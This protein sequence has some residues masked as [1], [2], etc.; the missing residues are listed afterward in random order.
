ME[1]RVAR[2]TLDIENKLFSRN[3][4]AILSFDTSINEFKSK[5]EL[6]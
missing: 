3:F 2:Q 4:L 1:E 6:A 5:I